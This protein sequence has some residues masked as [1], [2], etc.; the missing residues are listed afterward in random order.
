MLYG[1]KP[2]SGIIAHHHVL[3]QLRIHEKLISAYQWG[4]EKG[5]SEE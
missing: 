3:M 4:S 1:N 2:D 5:F